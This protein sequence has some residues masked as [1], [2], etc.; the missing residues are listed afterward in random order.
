MAL[1]SVLLLLLLLENSFG[2]D[3]GNGCIVIGNGFLVE[4]KRSEKLV[5]LSIY[6][7]FKDCND[8]YLH[9]GI[10]VQHTDSDWVPHHELRNLSERSIDLNKFI[11]DLICINGVAF[12]NNTKNGQKKTNIS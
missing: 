3:T 6:S 7:H 10:L 4:A 9:N 2:S 12:I 5:I 11:A 8:D 1:R